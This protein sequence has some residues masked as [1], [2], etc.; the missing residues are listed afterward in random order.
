MTRKL[1]TLHKYIFSIFFVYAFVSSWILP[2]ES[3]RILAINSIAGR[4]HWNY[5]SSVI[6]V[7]SKNGHNVTMFTPFPEG[8]RDNYT[9]IDT[10]NDHNEFKAMDLI[11]TMDLWGHPLSFFKFLRTNRNLMCDIVY[12]NDQLKKII[13]NNE[14]SNFDLLIIENVGHDCDLYLA[15]K[16]NL[17]FIYLISSPMITFAERSVSGDIPNPAVISH[18]YADHCIPKTLVQ[19]FSNTLL[20]GYNMILLSYDKFIRKFTMNRPYDLETSTKQPSLSFVNSH[21]ISE[22][23][24]PFPQN[25]IEIGGIHLKPPKKIP[26]DILEFIEN[27]PQGVILLTL[28]SVVNMSTS[29]DYILNPLKEALAEVP[30]RILWKYEAEYMVNKPKNVMIRKWLPQREILLHPKVKLFIS[31][32][33]MSGV[34]ETVHAGVP[35]LGFPLFYDQPRNIANLVNAGMAIS[36]DI[37]T[38]KKDAFLRNILELVNNKKYK[39]NAEIASDIFKNRPMSPEQSVLY[40]TEYVIRHKGAP[41]LKTHSLNLTWYQYLLL[42]IIAVI[43]VF[44]C[45]CLFLLYLLIKMFHKHILKN[46]LNT[47]AKSE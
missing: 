26:N 6:R 30:Q 47:K 39:R 32:G 27:S 9:E 17:P 5:V 15:N 18:L 43:I 35:V 44:I 19:R 25:L 16:L 45:I 3:A 14:G 21:F 42:D 7:L 33:G 29:P 20:L 24:R 28:G 36:M 1:N 41:H 4:S 46:V 2:I 34:Y 31:H 22:P 8:N 37:L 10:S 12:E 13:E 38:V 11:S 40:W 23:S